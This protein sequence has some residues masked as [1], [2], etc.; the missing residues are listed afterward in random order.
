MRSFVDFEIFTPGEHLSTAGEWTRERLLSGV[1]ANV[2]DQLVLGLEGFPFSRTVLPQARMV[3]LLRAADVFDGDVR[4]DFV[5][6]AERFVA[7]FPRLRLLVVDPQTRVFLFD[8]RPHVTEKRRR[9]SVMRVHGV[10][11]MLHVVD[12]IEMRRM[13]VLR[14]RAQVVDVI[15]TMP[16]LESRRGGVGVVEG[17]EE[18][19]ITNRRAALDVVVGHRTEIVTT[20]E[21]TGMRWS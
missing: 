10:H 12:V 4:H 6:G 11:G 1:N 8:G 5:H 14:A 9:R 19:V 20:A 15:G 16:V 2:V 3:R 7:S 18:D 13:K 21:H 17:W